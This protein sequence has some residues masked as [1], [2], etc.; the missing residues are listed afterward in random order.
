[1]K[2]EARPRQLRGEGRPRG[3]AAS[4]DRAASRPTRPAP[5]CSHPGRIRTC[6]AAVAIQHP[7]TPRRERI[8]CFKQFEWAD[9]PRPLEQA[10]QDVV[11]VG[12]L[13]AG[14]ERLSAQVR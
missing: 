8:A 9:D 13:R 10:E 7:L 2:S 1:M 11:R 5:S 12:G 4:S 3:K 14:Y 6:E